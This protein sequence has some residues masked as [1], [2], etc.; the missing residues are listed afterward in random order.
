MLNILQPALTTSL[1]SGDCSTLL[2][3]KMLVEMLILYNWTL[4]C[5]GK[6]SFTTTFYKVGIWVYYV[7]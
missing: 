6:Q 1:N 2:H 3:P 7:K 4:I 5:E